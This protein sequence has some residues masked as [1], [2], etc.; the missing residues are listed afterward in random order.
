[1]RCATL[2]YYSGIKMLSEEVLKQKAKKIRRDILDMVHCAGSGHIGGSMSAVEILLYLYHNKMN[3]KPDL[4]LWRE[5]DRFIM[6]KGHA[7]PVYYSVLSDRGF[8]PHDELK[9]FRQL[10]SCLQGHPDMKKT[11][12]VDFSSGSLGQ[13]LSVGCGMAWG[14]KNEGLDSKVYVLLGD[15]ELNEG[16]VWEAAMAAVKFKLNNLVAIIDHNGVQL[17]GFND[18]IMPLLSVA[19]KFKSF[20]WEVAEIN[21]HCFKEIGEALNK[22][23]D[24]PYAI[25][26]RTVKGKGVSFMENNHKWHGSPI[27]DEQY[28]Q[29]ICEIQ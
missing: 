21:G 4:P 25:V 20:G 29:A 3:I 28:N 12:G 10:N 8:F 7:T 13:G 5:R 2:K 11:K 1:L 26:A 23:Y 15:G 22:S 14:L 6:S 16:Q 9:T 18:E 19:E 17:D 24:K 27:N